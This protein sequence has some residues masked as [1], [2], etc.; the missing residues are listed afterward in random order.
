MLCEY[1]LNLKMQK[2]ILKD[3]DEIL[4]IGGKIEILESIVI[5]MNEYLEEKERIF[6]TQPVYVKGAVELKNY[7][8]RSKNVWPK[9]SG[10]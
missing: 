7:Y 8:F 10:F 1:Y 4:T 5:Q 2:V 6:L 9:N 3:R